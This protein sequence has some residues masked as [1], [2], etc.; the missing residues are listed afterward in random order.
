MGA[1]MV[2][3][4]GTMAL[5]GALA[6]GA[7]YLLSLMIDANWLGGRPALALIVASVVF[8]GGLM[9][10]AG[11]L[12]LIRAAAS[13]GVL[14]VVVA[15]LFT[16]AS[17]RYATPDAI[18]N[19]VLPMLALGVLVWLPWPFV[20]AGAG[21]GW[22]DYP[23]LFSEAWGIVVRVG[24]AVLFTAIVWG[25]IYLS[26]A[27]L[28]LV[29]VGFIRVL[30]DQAAVPWLVTGTVLGLALA[31]VNELTD[32][33][34]PGLVL[35]LFRLLVPVVL[36][37]MVI[38][39]IALPLRGFATI[40]GAVSSAM[41]LLAMAGAAVV[42]VTSALDQE[43]V[44]AAHTAL[45]VQS[46]RAMAAIVILPAGLAV[47]ALRLRVIDHGW[48]PDRLLAASV[49]V[50]ALMYGVLYLVAVLRGRGWMER[51]RQANIWMAF[52]MMA[53]A[54]LWL[55]VLN[56]EAISARSQ[57]A[58]IADGRTKAADIDL[59]AF[60]NGSLAGQAAMDQLRGL[61]KTNAGLA[62]RLAGYD[63]QPA[64]VADPVVAQK[65]LAA[66][67]P[68]QPDTPAAKAVRD[69]IL[70]AVLPSDLK[71]WQ[72]DCDRHLAT[73]G[74]ACVLVVA[75][76]LPGVAGDEAMLLAQSPDGYMF[77]EG[78]AFAGDALLRH[79]VTSYNGTLP[80][81][82]D[83]AALIDQLQKAP[84]PMAAVPLNQIALPGM[85]AL[86]FGP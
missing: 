60:Q 79:P 61:A 11:P 34:S 16:L 14:A 73:G 75:D 42:L 15:T 72:T 36:A 20:I 22:R 55:T 21:L 71:D 48:T 17:F 10:T 58:R 33:L 25:V 29:G 3:Q 30:L 38:F 53:L 1:G 76:F 54:A 27:L 85:P 80:G 63:G 39:L 37:V 32:V 43:D 67:L 12:T 35:R 64:P 50:L 51:I 62:A 83:G 59:Y 6:G 31:V 24:M 84:A 47:W 82:G 57:M 81:F 7:L 77:M 4:R 66:S 40:F 8:F 26:Q 46:A 69:Q 56:P 68:V 70:A 18:V 44:L 78:F 65:A 74:P 49:A 5:I 28:A 41:V 19:V 13:A 9:I 52:G 23:S 45:M 2:V 86:M